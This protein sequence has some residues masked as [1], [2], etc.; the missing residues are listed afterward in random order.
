MIAD[1]FRLAIGDLFASQMR[2]VLWKVVF[3]TVA[4]LFALW[5]ALHLS[6]IELALPWVE[7]FLPHGT[8]W[9]SW[10]GGSLT[11]LAAILLAGGTSLLLSPVSA[12]VAGLFLDDVAE[13]VERVHYPG[14]APGRAM[15]L[16]P[17]II[18][19]LKF[20][21]VIIVANLLALMLLLVPGVNLIA[22]FVVNGYLL[23]REYFEF[24]AMRLRPAPEARLFRRKHQRTILL[25]GFGI[26]AFLAVPIV[27]LLTPLFAAALMVHLHKRLSRAD[28]LY[29]DDLRR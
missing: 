18:G 9:Q 25:A 11:A 13:V 12:I 3:F 10:A 22:F 8:A 28:P 16:I 19:S 2:S 4:L 5:L 27:N 24:A 29:A 15:P 20:L 21:G 26:A 14:D 23:G 1:V 6:F 17:A 7:S